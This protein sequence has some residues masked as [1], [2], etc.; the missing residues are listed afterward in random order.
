MHPVIAEDRRHLVVDLSDG[1]PEFPRCPSL[2]YRIHRIKIR[3]AQINITLG[4]GRV[5][6]QMK[7]SDR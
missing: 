7:T 6:M 5:T 1:K 2:A 4:I 3:Q